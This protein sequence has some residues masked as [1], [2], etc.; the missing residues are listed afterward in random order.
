MKGFVLGV[1]CASL[2]FG[3]YLYWQARKAEAPAPGPA[4]VEDDAAS[5]KK[6]RRRRRRPRWARGGDGAE[7]GLGEPPPPIS[8]ADRKMVAKG[9]SLSRPDVIRMDVDE[10]G[11]TRE[12]TQ[13]D[14]DAQFRAREDAILECIAEARPH[15][16]SFIP[17]LVNVKFRIQRSGAI[18]GVRVEAPAI[19]QKGGIYGCIKGVVESLRYPPSGSSQIVTY[20]FRLG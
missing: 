20:P 2:V 13:T 19:L 4:V 17:G 9:D 10:G 16:E 11:A 5:S 12:L 7:M 14:I 18:D 1:L 6:N 8:A 15:P 3:G